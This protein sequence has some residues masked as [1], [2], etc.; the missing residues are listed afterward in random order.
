MSNMNTHFDQKYQCLEAEF[1]AQCKRDGS[2][3]LPNIE[4][5]QRVD[6]FLVCMEPSFGRWANNSTDKANELV[7]Q[8]YRNF[9]WSTEDFILHYCAQRY[10]CKPGQRYHV[11]DISKGAMT[12]ADANTDRKM[13][14]K[15]WLPLLKREIALLSIP[16]ATIISVG[17]AVQ[18]ELSRANIKN[19]PILHF[20]PLASGARNKSVA[21]HPEDY[22]AYRE[23]LSDDLLKDMAKE[24]IAASALPGAHP[25]L[26]G[27]IDKIKLTESRKKL[28]YSYKV[29]FENISN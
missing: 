7:Q 15:K 10:L 21:E 8:G 18:A 23:S 28:L 27:R 6:Y 2:V 9:L 16:S 29:L 13:R 4:P 12:V 17:N 11:T 26:Q 25:L 24:A 3:Y 19:S 22:K 20:S 1:R 14:Y 5:K